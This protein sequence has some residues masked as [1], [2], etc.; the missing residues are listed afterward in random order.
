M[1]PLPQP[2]IASTQVPSC[3]PPD[4]TLPR[5]SSETG[6]SVSPG[7]SWLASAAAIDPSSIFAC[8]PSQRQMPNRLRKVSATLVQIS[9]GWSVISPRPNQAIEPMVKTMKP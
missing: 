8:R 2:A 5:V 9:A 7:V 3:V 6:N 4:I 1:R